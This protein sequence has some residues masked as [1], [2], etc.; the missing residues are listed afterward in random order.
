MLGIKIN[1]T[2]K[3]RDHIMIT[4]IMCDL[5]HA[6]SEIIDN[7]ISILNPLND[8]PSTLTEAITRTK[9]VGENRIY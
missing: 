7:E 4:L 3:E 9:D 1:H 6:S 2:L 5:K 8:M